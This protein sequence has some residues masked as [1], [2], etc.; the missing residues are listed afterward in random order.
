[1]GWVTDTLAWYTF[2][3]S[4]WPIVKRLCE[5]RR[6]A[7]VYGYE[8]YGVP[9]ARRAADRFDVPMIAR[10]QGTLMSVRR[11]ERLARLRYHK[12]L[13]ALRTPADLVIMTDD[14]TQGDHVLSRLGHPADRVRFWMNGVSRDI[15]TSPVTGDEVRGELGIGKDAPVLL[16]VSRL[17]HWKR[18]DRAIDVAAALRERGL[19]VELVVVGSGPEESRLREH[20]AASGGAGHVR[21][22]GGVE[23]DRLAGFYRMADVLLSLYDYSNLA[24]PVLEAMVLGVPVVALGTGGTANLVRDGEN[25]TLVTSTATADVADA[26]ERLLREPQAARALGERA[27]SWAKGGLWDWDARMSAELDELRAIAA[28]PRPRP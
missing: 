1:V 10:Y 2:G 27:A 3:S 28:T 20:A 6:P 15:A 13:A 9:V 22:V 19:P 26:T 25:G 23:R 21:F 8:I 17:S 11:H 16:T 12:H 4:A 14:G 18:V 7:L 24:N 5:E